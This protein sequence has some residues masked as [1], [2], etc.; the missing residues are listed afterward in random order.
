MILSVLILFPILYLLKNLVYTFRKKT[1]VTCFVIDLNKNC[2]ELNVSLL[3]KR[4][5][6][7]NPERKVSI[8]RTLSLEL[9][10]VLSSWV[11]SQ[12]T[13]TINEIFGLPDAICS[14]SYYS[15]LLLIVSSLESRINGIRNRH[16]LSKTTLCEELFKHVFYTTV[17]YFT[18]KRKDIQTKLGL[19]PRSPAHCSN[20]SLDPCG[21]TTHHFVLDSEYIVL[22]V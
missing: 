7:D 4:N 17:G 21:L 1:F 10:L 5:N 13:V 20:C 2:T 3:L 15:Q 18:L 11:S 19:R 6:T 16:K 22:W 9:S 8:K 12:I 14:L